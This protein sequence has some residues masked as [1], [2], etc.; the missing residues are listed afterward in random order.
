MRKW[1]KSGKSVLVQ[2]E[3]DTFPLG[4]LDEADYQETRIPMSIGDKVILYTDGI[5]EAKNA[6]GELFGFERLLEIVNEGRSDG[7]N[8]L[9]NRILAQVDSFVGQAPQHDDLTVIVISRESQ[10]ASTG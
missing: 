4:I 8:T 6:D 1:H 5:V 10:K 7:A 9:M 3:G 2:T